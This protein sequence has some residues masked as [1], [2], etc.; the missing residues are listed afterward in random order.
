MRP[1]AASR[2]TTLLYSACSNLSPT[3][4]TG[5]GMSPTEDPPGSLLWLGR[6][7]TSEGPYRLNALSD[8][9]WLRVRA[10]LPVPPLPATSPRLGF[11]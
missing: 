10:F 5:I 3:E 9:I 6:W 8:G 7:E 4:V 11:V 2:V 1:R